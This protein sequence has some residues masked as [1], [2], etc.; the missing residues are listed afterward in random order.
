MND[1]AKLERLLNVI[2]LLS[3]GIRRT[4][5]ELAQKLEVSER[6]IRRYFSTI[7]NCGFIII[8]KEGHYFIEKLQ[9]P[10]K[11][12]NNLL[13][14]S[15]EEASILLKAIHS[16]DE[17]N[18]L[19]QN[20]EKKLYSLYKI[21]PVADMIFNKRLSEVVGYLNIAITEKKQVILRSYQSAH[22]K[23]IRD[24]LV[25]PFEFTTNL[26]SFWA[27]DPEDRTNKTFK[28]SRTNK[29]EVLNKNWQYVAEHKSLPID[30]FRISSEE[31][32]AVKIRMNLR[33]YNL[34]IEEYPLSEQY[35][36][37]ET[38]I[39]RIFEGWVCSFEGIGRFV[40]GLC[41]DVEILEPPGLK[42]FVTNKINSLQ[43]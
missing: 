40:T 2:I 31:K 39:S 37:T 15:E 6:T 12:L 21:S 19:K 41:A 18:I 14:F 20:L 25:E 11:K 27:Y 43:E 5:A 42:E 28:T 34:L 23:I 38:D 7:E 24:R 13:T 1:Q 30:V 35:I 33:A 26:Q 36:R 16:I 4:S 22:S 17:N 9:E 32:I 8:R 3:S 29:V 10:F